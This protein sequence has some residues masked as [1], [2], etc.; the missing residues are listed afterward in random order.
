LNHDE[1]RM[2]RNQP[3]LGSSDFDYKLMTPRGQRVSTFRSRRPRSGPRSRGNARS[4]RAPRYHP[5]RRAITPPRS[6]S[7]SSSPAPSPPPLPSRHR[8][9]RRW[10]SRD[11]DVVVHHR[12]AHLALLLPTA[13][14]SRRPP[15]V[16]S[17]RAPPYVCSGQQQRRA[18][19]RC[20]RTARTYTSVRPSG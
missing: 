5:P 6:R 12:T 9:R 10:R 18:A 14:T 19:S 20:A 2:H 17:C 15:D 16:T 11:D 7:S 3:R 1:S 13:A 4:G 8:R